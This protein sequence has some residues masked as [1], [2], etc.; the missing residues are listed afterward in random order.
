MAMPFLMGEKPVR[1]AG[2][3]GPAQTVRGCGK[4]TTE[5]A[6]FYRPKLLMEIKKLIQRKLKKKTPWKGG[7]FML[8]ATINR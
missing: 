3:S 4:K 7:L 5:R 2:P 1:A 8:P 6:P